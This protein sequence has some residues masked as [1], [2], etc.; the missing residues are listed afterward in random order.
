MD[1]KIYR[2]IIL[3]RILVLL[4]IFSKAFSIPDTE[5]LLT[6]KQSIT[7]PEELYTWQPDSQ[8]CISGA[9]KNNWDGIQCFDGLVTGLR[10]GNMGLS[11]KIDIDMLRELPGLRSISIV[12]NSFS[13]T[14]PEFYRLGSLRAIYLSGNQFSGEISDDYFSPMTSLRKVWLSNNKFT[15]KIPG[16]LGQLP[17]LLELHIENNEFI[18]EIP[19]FDRTKLNQIDFSNNKLQGDIPDSLIPFKPDAFIGNPSLCGQNLGLDCNHATKPEDVHVVTPAE[20]PKNKE[21]EKVLIPVILIS[22]LLFLALIVFGIC[23]RRKSEQFKMLEK[24]VGMVEAVEVQV[25]SSA[26]KKDDSSNRNVGSKQEGDVSKRATG[27]SRKGS[28]HGKMNSMPEFILVNDEKGVFGLPDLMKAAAE[29]LG[30]GGLGSSYKAVLTNGLA[31]VVKRMRDMNALDKDDFDVHIKRLVRLKHPNLLGPLGYH[32]RK[33]EKL[34]VYE[35][36][37][38]GSLLYLLHGEIVSMKNFSLN[39]SIM[40]FLK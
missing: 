30:N 12:N 40:S 5:A 7:N 29:V 8:P 16:S 33:E 18:G 28:N 39:W 22:L 24:N 11:G 25:T 26:S 15:G 32:Y 27:S 14:I 10:L 31:V 2:K 3:R 17:N 4:I 20:H 13:G 6:F 35:Y 37:P 21:S 34:L 23:R 19:N 9:L 38:K 36:I 1:V